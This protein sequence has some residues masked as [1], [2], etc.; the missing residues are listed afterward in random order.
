MRCHLTPPPS[1]TNVEWL[2][3]N[4]GQVAEDHRA[5]LAGERLDA[6]RFVLMANFTLEW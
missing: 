1:S 2:F 5:S 3:S 6:M 4:V